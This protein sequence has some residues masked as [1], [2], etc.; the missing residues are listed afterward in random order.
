MWKR[1]Y[2]IA[3]KEYKSYVL[4]FC[5]PMSNEETLKGYIFNI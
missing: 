1:K 3:K 2:R 4:Q 5:R